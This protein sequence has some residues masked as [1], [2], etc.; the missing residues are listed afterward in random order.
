[1]MNRVNK[2]ERRWRRKRKDRKKVQMKIAM[3]IKDS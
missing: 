1:M 3:G 2:A